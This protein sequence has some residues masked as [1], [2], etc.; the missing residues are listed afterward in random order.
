VEQQLSGGLKGYTQLATITALLNVS[1][2]EPY[3]HDN[4]LVGVPEVG[5]EGSPQVIKLSTLY[6]IQG[7]KAKFRLCSPEEDH[8]L[9]SFE[10]LLEGT[11]RDIVL[12]YM[13]VDLGKYKSVFTDNKDRKIIEI[14]SNTKE[15][16]ES[17]SRLNKWAAYVSKQQNLPLVQFRNARHILVDARPTKALPLSVLVKELGSIIKQQETRFGYAT[18][19]LDNWRAVSTG[20]EST[21]YYYIPGFKFRPCSV[22][23]TLSASA[24]V[25]NASHMFAQSLKDSRK[26]PLIGVHIRG[27]R[28]LKEYKGNFVNCF[29]NLRHLLHN[30][31]WNS[32]SVQ[33]RVVHD[34]GKYGTKSC[35]SCKKGRLK[36]LSE[37]NKFGHPVVYFDP[38]KFPSAPKSSA[39]ASFVEREYLSNLDV[40]V[41]VGW[42]GFQHSIYKKFL[43]Y[44][45]GNEKKLHRICSSPSS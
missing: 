7:L 32:S 43:D 13:L 37:V 26:H 9:S 18:L 1:S 45:N 16:Q 11:S 14:D 29:Q 27:E 8:E 23:Q 15:A 22:I 4:Q 5:K 31:G 21:F 24:A 17:M 20:G 2:V 39:F 35:T 42:G 19:V 12:V 30:S 3:V 25:V 10:T 36:F 44:H 41:T 34:F 6:D 38:N 28:L 33:V 40:L